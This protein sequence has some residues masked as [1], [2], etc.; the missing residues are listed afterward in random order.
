VQRGTAS[1]TEDCWK[2][3]LSAVITFTSKQTGARRTGKTLPLWPKGEHGELPA[4]NDFII[5]FFTVSD[6]EPAVL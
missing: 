4:L 1:S 5:R 3:Q 6:E 2:L